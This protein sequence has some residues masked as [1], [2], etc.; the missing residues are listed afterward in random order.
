MGS[1]V[2]RVLKSSSE[3]K[4]MRPIRVLPGPSILRLCLAANADVD[5]RAFEV[6][7]INNVVPHGEYIRVVSCFEVTCGKFLSIVAGT[8]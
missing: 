8:S 5:S 2:L 4:S 3:A 7:G 1:I 6:M